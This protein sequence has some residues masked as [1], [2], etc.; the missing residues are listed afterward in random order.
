MARGVKFT[1]QEKKELSRIMTE[2]WKRK[3]GEARARTKPVDL[4][5]DTL[6]FQSREEL[7]IGAG[8]H[9]NLATKKWADLDTWIQ[10]LLEGSLKTRSKGK[11]RLVRR[12]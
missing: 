4:S 6:H 2:A 10:K 12:G 11:A 9:K 1:T 8:M 5:W 3:R 7:L